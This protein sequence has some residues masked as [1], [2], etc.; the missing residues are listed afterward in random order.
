MSAFWT[1]LPGNARNVVFTIFD[2]DHASEWVVKD[3]LATPSDFTDAMGVNWSRLDVIQVTGDRLVVKLE[4]AG[5]LQADAIRIQQVVGDASADNDFHV[6]ATSPTI[7]AGN[8]ASAFANEPSPNGGRVNLGHTGNTTEATTSPAQFVQVLSPNGL[9]KIEQNQQVSIQWRSFGLPAI[10]EGN[11]TIELIN[12]ATSAISTIAAT[13]PND[14]EFLWTVPAGLAPGQYRIR[15]TASAGIMPSDTSDMPFVVANAGHDYYVNDASLVGDVFTTAIGNN[16]NSGKTPDAPM[17]SIGAVLA[18]YNLDEGDVIHVDAGTYNL[19][20][21]IVIDASDS[22]VRV[23]GPGAIGSVSVAVINRGN[24]VSGSYVFQITG[25]DDVTLDHLNITGGEYGVVLAQ[26]TDAD[27]LTVTS[28]E[29]YGNYRQGIYIGQQSDDSRLEDNLLYNN[30][31][32]GIYAEGVTGLI[33][34]DNVLHN[35]NNPGFGGTGITVYTTGPSGNMSTISGNESYGNDLGMYVNGNA[36]IEVRDNLVHD[37]Y[38]GIAAYNNALV[39]QNEVYLNQ[40]Y[41][42]S[43]GYGIAATSS[44]VVDNVIHDNDR[45]IDASSAT[46]R[47]NRVFH[48][49]DIGIQSSGASSIIDNTIYGNNLGIEATGGDV[50]RNNLIYDNPNDGIWIRTGTDTLIENN[51]IYQP[52]TGDAIQIA[53]LHP[54]VPFTVSPVAR[55]TIRNNILRVAEGYAINV[56]AD[57]EIGFASDYNDF[58]IAGSGKLVRWEDH[59]FT[60]REDWFFEVGGDI[61]SIVADPQFVD[62]DGADDHLGF[63]TATSTDYGLDD[64]FRIPGTSSTIDAGDPTSAYGLEPAP[65]GGRVNLGHTG[66]TADAATSAA[67]VVQVLSPNGLEKL[68]QGQ[69]VTIQWQSAGIAPADYY[70]SAILADSPLAYYRL[71]E[72]SG[73]SAAE[74]SGTNLDG[75]YVGGVQLGAH[76][77]LLADTN[78]AVQLNGSSGYVQLPAGFAD[79][80]GGFSAEMWVYPTAVGSWQRLFDLGNGSASNNIGLA[81]VANSNDLEFFVY[82]GGSVVGAVTAT[83]VLEL[84][85]WQHFAVTMSAGGAVAIYKNGQ[86]VAAGTSGLPQNTTRTSNYLGKSNWADALFAGRMDEAAFYDHALTPAELLD[87]YN[88]RLYGDVTIQLERVGS[89]QQQSIAASALNT[90]QFQWTV[91]AGQTEGQYRILVTANQGVHPSDISDAPFLI[92]NSGTDYYIN[93]SS[94]TN[95]VFATAAG[96][97]FASGKS[98]D[99]PMA[100]LPALLAAYDLDAGDVIHADTGTYRIYRNARLTAQ[101][102]GVRIEGPG[103]LPAGQTLEA[104]AV[105]NRSNT[106]SSQWVFEL[107]GADDV[108][109]DHLAATRGEY[110]IFAPSS[111]DSD[112]LTV[113]ASDIYDNYI[114]GIYIQAGNEDA[115]ILDN[116]AHGHTVQNSSTGIAVEAARALIQGNDVFG[117][118]YGISA[119]YSGLLADRI[120]VDGNRARSNTSI[121][122]YA[123]NQVL[124]SDNTAYDQL[125]SGAVGIYVS[126]PSYDTQTIDNVSFHNDVGILAPPAMESFKQSKITASS[127]TQSAFE[128]ATAAKCWATK[129]TQTTPASA[130]IRSTAS[131]GSSQTT[132]FMPM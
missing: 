94:L 9:E 127:T 108:V 2:D 11:A 122:I 63:D 27:R 62:I 88:H 131:K 35:N 106:T 90:G 55:T 69:Q 37:N 18:A 129:S 76:G 83:G 67:Q 116:Q 33:V 32:G 77:P 20:K 14:G 49:R 111:A 102:S 48:N 132:S 52:T 38:S 78:S 101:D 19:V 36:L 17:A 7:D 47:S 59:D 74:I 87:H 125:T 107:A 42:W 75:T 109:L 65:N 22:G 98:P 123:Q 28:S 95:D 13:T 103:A 3:L 46:I 130:A 44:T 40:G 31:Q 54:D 99:Q 117:N 34:R 68:E 93:D 92:V 10:P 89:G 4:G 70:S 114:H 105:F 97:N 5:K 79:F 110:G 1:A 58:V 16:A 23:E 126:S 72:T 45:G 91:A 113:S 12:V 66:N 84:N 6:T 53:G 86:Q 120:V 51:T 112:R 50:I 80:S 24:T 104:A 43:I 85:T 71:G 60:T 29:I 73:T 64:D 25:A 41:H 124:V 56:A 61:H 128:P 30:T 15:V 119:A 115:Q 121:G 57:S 81:R 82:S 96:N 100:S 26:Y 21:N 8:P 39:T 118:A